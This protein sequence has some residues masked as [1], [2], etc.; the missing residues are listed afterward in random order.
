MTCAK[1]SH[2]AA[3][4][5]CHCPACLH[6]Q[7]IFVEKML[8]QAATGI[9]KACQRFTGRPDWESIPELLKRFTNSGSYPFCSLITTTKYNLDQCIS[10]N[11]KTLIFQFTKT[12]PVK[13]AFAVQRFFLR[14]VP[15]ICRKSRGRILRHI[16]N[17][18]LK[19]FPPCYSH[20]P[21]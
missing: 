18:S 9:D 2:V 17:K 12:T 21:L 1:Y 13:G 7:R 20:A 4:E 15:K 6:Y 5:A 3:S 16:W 11:K 19:G 8:Q 10:A 14:A